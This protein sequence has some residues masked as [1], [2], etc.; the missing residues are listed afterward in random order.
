MAVGFRSGDVFFVGAATGPFGRVSM[1]LAGFLD[2]MSEHPPRLQA[3][4]QQWFS[5]APGFSWR[6]DVPTTLAA[7]SSQKRG[8]PSLLNEQ[9]ESEKSS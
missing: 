5:L 1:G 3:T 6:K 7:N 4:T 2:S 9:E 8:L